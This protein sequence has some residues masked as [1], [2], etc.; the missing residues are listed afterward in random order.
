[1]QSMRNTDHCSASSCLHEALGNLE[2]PEDCETSFD[3]SIAVLGRNEGVVMDR[4]DVPITHRQISLLHVLDT[5][6]LYME[7]GASNKVGP[8]SRICSLSALYG[9]QWVRRL[10]RKTLISTFEHMALWP[11]S[12]RMRRDQRETLDSTSRNSSGTAKPLGR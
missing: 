1:M 7:A 5:L 8:F 3:A 9:S 10:T 6:D 2:T 12:R 11:L 4:C